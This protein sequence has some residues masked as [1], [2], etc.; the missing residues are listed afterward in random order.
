MGPS[1]NERPVSSRGCSTSYLVIK[2]VTMYLSF[3]LNQDEATQLLL[4]D[5]NRLY[6]SGWQKSFNFLPHNFS[7][8][9]SSTFFTRPQMQ[10]QNQQSINITALNDNK[11]PCIPTIQCTSFIQ[12]NKQSD[13]IFQWIY[14]TTFHALVQQLPLRF[15]KLCPHEYLVLLSSPIFINK[16]RAVLTPND[17]MTWDFHKKWKWGTKCTNLV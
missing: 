1:R 6:N 2:H 4:K 13:F 11:C 14:I 7:F 16:K 15:T 10:N 17:L 9:R 3:K 5:P 12:D 8:F